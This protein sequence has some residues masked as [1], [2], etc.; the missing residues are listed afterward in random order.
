[1]RRCEETLMRSFSS[2]FLRILSS[3]CIS[4]FIIAF[5]SQLTHFCLLFPLSVHF[6]MPLIGIASSFCFAEFLAMT[7]F[8]SIYRL[9]F[10]VHI[11]LHFAFYILLFYTPLQYCY[12]KV[13][14]NEKEN[15]VRWEKI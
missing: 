7:F 9:L 13:V 5:N 6:S 8:P 11:S 10:T 14:F 3:F 2:T 1:M 12:F 15:G 4:H